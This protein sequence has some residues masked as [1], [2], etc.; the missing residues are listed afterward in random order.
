LYARLTLPNFAFQAIIFIFA[1]CM[2][3]GVLVYCRLLV[4]LLVMGSFAGTLLAKTVLRAEA[5]TLTANKAKTTSD[6]S[7]QK[8]D[9][10]EQVIVSTQSA[11]TFVTLPAPNFEALIPLEQSYFFGKAVVVSP[12]LLRAQLQSVFQLCVHRNLFFTSIQRSAP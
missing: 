10:G 2:K 5:Y 4:L 11:T 3:N 7:K 1:G 12:A 8:S 6:N 9:A